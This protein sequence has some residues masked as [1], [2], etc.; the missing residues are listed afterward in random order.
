RLLELQSSLE[1]QP[2]RASS[3]DPNSGA[4]TANRHRSEAVGP[5]AH[6]NRNAEQSSV[7]QDQRHDSVGSS[8]VEERVVEGVSAISKSENR[9][10]GAEG[11][12]APA[13]DGEVTNQAAS[14]QARRDRSRTS[15]RA[16]DELRIGQSDDF[17]AGQQRARERAQGIATHGEDFSR[18]FAGIDYKEG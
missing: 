1:Q 7:F 14:P 8:T 12:P 16:L 10:S 17:R 4:R 11:E 6:G 9:G 3:G 15:T 5:G 2:D 13:S 18:R